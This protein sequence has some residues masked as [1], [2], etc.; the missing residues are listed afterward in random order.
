MHLGFWVTYLGATYEIKCNFLWSLKSLYTT[1]FTFFT[2]AVVEIWEM[3]IAAGVAMIKVSLSKKKKKKSLLWKSRNTPSCVYCKSYIYKKKS[4][5]N[6]S[7]YHNKPHS[8]AA[9]SWKTCRLTYRLYSCVHAGSLGW[10]L[11]GCGSLSITACVFVRRYNDQFYNGEFF[12]VKC[13]LYTGSNW[14]IFLIIL[15]SYHPIHGP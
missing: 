13:P 11:W 4:P 3:L 5:G 7:S 15:S 2:I 12:F 9:T 8:T 14:I 10:L 1:F 6:P